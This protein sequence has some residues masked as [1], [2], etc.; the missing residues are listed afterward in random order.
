MKYLFFFFL[1][2]TSCVHKLAE[3][4]L[5]QKG[6]SQAEVVKVKSVAVV[7]F[8]L[9]QYQPTGLA[10]KIGGSAS[11]HLS[12]AQTAG[13][14]RVTD[15]ELAQN[16]YQ[17]LL[18]KITETQSWKVT[19]L[20]KLT[21]NLSYQKLL[22]EKKTE[23]GEY[24]NATNYHK[25]YT[26]KGVMRPLNPEYQFSKDEVEILT[27]SLGVDAIVIAE[28]K[29]MLIRNDYLGLGIANSYLTP[30]FSFYLINSQSTKP[31]W[32]DYGYEGPRSQESM[33]KVSGLEDTDKIERETKSLAESAI[34][35]FFKSQ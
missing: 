25:L 20:E 4:A 18:S 22:A 21:I 24:L 12:A 9:M 31:I 30:Y 14:A 2:L 17:H 3:Q 26:V 35:N 33:G 10:S 7:A 16:L 19:P 6:Y 23:V 28:I 32:F 5:P 11:A 8:S 13:N 27:K 1:L 15:S 34:Y 29:M